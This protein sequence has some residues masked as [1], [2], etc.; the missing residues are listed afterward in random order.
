MDGEEGKREK[1]RGVVGSVVDGDE[2]K[3]RKVGMWWD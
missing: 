3:R 2:G 1:V